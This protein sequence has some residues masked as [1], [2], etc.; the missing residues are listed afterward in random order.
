MSD[1]KIQMMN[2]IQNS[3]NFNEIDHWYVPPY[4]P[5]IQTLHTTSPLLTGTTEALGEPE[6]LL[7][8]TTVTACTSDSHCPSV[9]RLTARMPP[10]SVPPA[11]GPEVGGDAGV[12][13][14]GT[15][16]SMSPVGAL[17]RAPRV[18]WK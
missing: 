4:P 10:G 9:L 14:R 11:A 6:L 8:G 16:P 3:M 7:A 18:R 2:L 15:G 13:V 5:P 17:T 12:I 1:R